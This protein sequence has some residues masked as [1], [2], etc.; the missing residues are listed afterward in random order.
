MDNPFP[1][2]LYPAKPKP[3]RDQVYTLLDHLTDEDIAY[4]VDR[5]RNVATDAQ[6]Q[7]DALEAYGAQRRQA[8]LDTSGRSARQAPRSSSGTL[9]EGQH[10]E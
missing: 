1:G 10:G 3:D 6:Q 5:L 2:I 4:N 7:A 9:V 8:C